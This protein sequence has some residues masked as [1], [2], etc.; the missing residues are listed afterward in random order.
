MSP[1]VEAAAPRTKLTGPQAFVALL[2]ILSA[3]EKSRIQA[4]AADERGS[5]VNLNDLFNLMFRQV[6]EDYP[7][8]SQPACFMAMRL[9]PWNDL[10]G[11]K[12]SMGLA[13]RRCAAAAPRQ[14]EAI[15]RR[16]ERL[17]VQPHN[18]LFPA[19]LDA[20]RLL[21]KTV[22]ARPVGPAVKHRQGIAID[23]PQ[24]INDL[25]RWPDAGERVQ[26]A[27]IRDFHNEQ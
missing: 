15:H 22:P 2:E 12:G 8:L 7:R 21:R 6:K 27:W 13:L 18:T 9:Y 26:Q 23:W 3:P 4:H 5:D 10:P 20:V 14:Y 11:G 24:L 16:F 19:L 25:T 17:V 1:P